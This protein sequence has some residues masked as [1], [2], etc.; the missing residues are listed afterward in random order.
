MY[1][2]RLLAFLLCVSHHY[3]FKSSVLCFACAC[4]TMQMAFLP[5]N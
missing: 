5:L 1:D 2:V 3:Q 4:A